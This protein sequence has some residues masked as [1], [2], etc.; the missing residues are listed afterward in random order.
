M[1]LNK[2]SLGAEKPALTSPVR[3]RLRALFNWEAVHSFLSCVDLTPALPHRGTLDEPRGLFL[4]GI[5][6]WSHF[7]LCLADT[8]HRRTHLLGAALDDITE[9]ERVGRA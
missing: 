2:Y 9:P 8:G 1:S 6:P 5:R 7:A 3:S 4:K